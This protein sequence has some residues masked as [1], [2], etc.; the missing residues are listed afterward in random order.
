MKKIFNIL[1]KSWISIIAVIV[2][3]FIQ[4]NCDLALPDYTSNII[5]IGIQQ[6][7]IENNTYNVIRKSEMDKLLIFTDK[8]TDILNNYTLV[9]INDQK[10]IKK[11]PILKDEEIYILK[12]KKNLDKYFKTPLLMMYVFTNEE[13]SSEII[14]NMNIPEGMD[15]FT[16][17]QNMPYENI[18][19][20]EKGINEKMDDLTSTMVDQ[21]T[22][23][24]I[25]E[26]YKTVGLNTEKLQI[27]YIVK[28]GIQM[29]LLALVIM[30]I[31]I[32]TTYLS[33]RIGSLFSK[34][35]RSNVVKKVMGYS[36]KEFDSL[37][38]SSLITRCTNDI[39]QI[40]M[41]LIMV[42]RIVIY[43]PILGFGA[44]GKVSGSP[45]EWITGVAVLTILSLVVILFSISIPKFKKLQKLVDKLNLVSREILTGIPVIR[46]FATEKYEE[47]KFDNANKDL[48]K[49]NLFVNKVMTFMMP[50]MMFIMYAVEIL[51]VW[52][53]A[54][55]VN[56]GTMQVG[57]IFAFISYTMQIIMAF[58]M[59]SMVSIMLP[60]AW[61]SV[62]RIAEVFNKDTSVKDPINPIK[63]KNTKTSTVE[64]KDVYFRYPDAEEDVLENIS[65]KANPGTITAFI[66]STGSGKSTLINLIPRF[67]DVTGGKILING[68]N[69]K[70]ISLHDLRKNIGFVPQKGNLFSGTIE[71]NIMFGKKLTKEELKKVAKIAQA[72]SFIEEKEDKYKSAISQDGSNVSGGQKQRLAIARAIAINPSIY[73]FDDSFSALDYKTDSNLRKELKKQ[74]KDSTIFIV[75]QRISTVLNADQIIVLDEGK[76]VGI[77]N[78]KELMKKC[79][80]YK[81][82]A[83][84]QLSEEELNNE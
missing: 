27:D 83:L 51:I 79:D 35:L 68:V 57:D 74:T 19:E 32:T 23:N 22:V 40:Q 10:Y 44:L 11:Y 76:I 8:D 34:D 43:A 47:E 46:A 58:L 63:L 21:M 14:K 50:T 54:D 33:S 73:V 5:N 55:K 1:K 41:L 65:F 7:G 71:S 3:L 69:I 38:T 30:I 60:R 39:T 2:L 52:I 77:G 28:L 12:D 45:L 9:N 84:S 61:V 62:K 25:K 16:V 37:S 64:F 70:D 31:T 75:A 66:G 80:V 24:L 81:E 15:I 59:I 53:G 4:A 67:F 49:T 36:N 18:I 29:V 17:L 82:I 6:G 56:L 48:T 26:E 20:I 72:D 42:L 78:H 13:M